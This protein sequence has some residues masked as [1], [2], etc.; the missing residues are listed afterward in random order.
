MMKTVLILLC[1]VGFSLANPTRTLHKKHHESKR[2]HPIELS[3]AWSYMA[4][5]SSC[6]DAEAIER[7]YSDYVEALENLEAAGSLY[8]VSQVLFN[9]IL[10][11]PAA[12]FTGDMVE[13]CSALAYGMKDMIEMHQR[14]DNA[15]YKSVEQ[16]IAD[17]L[18]EE[19]EEAVEADGD[20]Q[21]VLPDPCLPNPDGGAVLDSLICPAGQEDLHTLPFIKRLGEDLQCYV[22]SLKEKLVPFAKENT[23][24]VPWDTVL[25]VLNEDSI[26]T[27]EELSSGVTEVL[28]GIC[29]AVAELPK[30]WGVGSCD[31]YLEPS[32]KK[33]GLMLAIRKML[34]RRFG[35][36]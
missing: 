22:D 36:F 35:R 19:I 3:P 28:D 31:D 24:E 1:L 13:V 29:K 32:E 18:G 5:N 2:Q 10:G 34:A 14:M 7:G 4:Y 25:A 33:R 20:D 11:T 30:E 16:Y 8:D 27:L 15:V 23:E 17:L 6:V 26:P 12:C 9:A 21:W